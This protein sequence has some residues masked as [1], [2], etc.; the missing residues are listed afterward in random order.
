MRALFWRLFVINGLLFAVGTLVLAFSPATV[1]SPLLLTEVPILIVGL[2]LILAA[3]ALLVRGSL[4]P[5][6]ALARVMER[7]DLIRTGDRRI[8][9]GNGDLGHLLST[10][11]QMIDRL[12]SEHATRSAH[13]LAAQEGERQRIARELHDEIGQSLTVAL[14]SLKPVVDRAP[15]G[16][17]EEVLQAQEAVRSSLDEVRQV[18]HRLRPGVLA[19][20]G[21]ESALRSLCT[22]FERSSGVP[23]RLD[24]DADLGDLGADTELVLYRV[25]Q[26][27]LTN[28]ARHAGASRV[29]LALTAEEGQVVLVIRDDGRG[30]EFR[31]G[32][33]IRG[34]RERALL[35]GAR[36]TVENS[37]AGG[38]VVQLTVREPAAEVTR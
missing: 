5:L 1:S 24:V 9:G 18:A 32:A 26:E 22:E 11:H 36:L 8:D 37:S 7:V 23:V 19:D 34:M 35:I 33:G 15:D 30:G 6:D 2:A 27:G 38:T 25:A 14:L 16:F 13:A 10:F 28:V 31:E 20:L 17:R 21:L 4:A 12:E 3:N 29:R